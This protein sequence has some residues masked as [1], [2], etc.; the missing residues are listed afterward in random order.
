[1]AFVPQ[2]AFAEGGGG[3][4]HQGAGHEGTP[5]IMINHDPLPMG[6]DNQRMMDEHH[7]SGTPDMHHASGTPA[8]H[9]C[10]RPPHGQ[11]EHGDD[12][13][14]SSTTPNPIDH[15]LMNGNASGTPAMHDCPRPPRHE[16]QEGEQGDMHTG[17]SHTEDH[18]G[19][20]SSLVQNLSTMSQDQMQSLLDLLLKLINLLQKGA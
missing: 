4:H 6:D 16:G 2:G 18:T 10:P 19:G 7:A 3:D 11:G 15:T 5:Q 17:P 12:M 8:M 9:D 1:M 20:M 13:H 14:M